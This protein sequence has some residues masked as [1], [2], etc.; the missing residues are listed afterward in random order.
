MSSRPW[1]W[2]I[3]YRGQFFSGNNQRIYLLGNPIIWWGNIVFL[4]LFVVLY[5]HA[6][7][8]EQ[9][10]C[11]DRPPIVRERR[12]LM[13]AGQWLFIGWILHYV[14]FWGMSRVLYFHHYFPALLYSSMLTGVTI[15]YIVE[16]VLLL[17]PRTIG[18]M[19]YHLVLG[20]VI[21]SSIYSFYLFSP[22][23]YGM[24]GPSAMDPESPMHTLRW[25]DTWEF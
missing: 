9:R 2:P 11:T 21:S 4:I 3:N 19:V 22:L 18:Y 7:V 13:D 8:R 6:C 17:L 1:Q 12:K 24:E 5:V 25:M 16:S 20:S 15:N 14:P 23:A 10:G